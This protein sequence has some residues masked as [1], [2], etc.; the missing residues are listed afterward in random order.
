MTKLDF[1]KEDYK[2]TLVEFAPGS[3]VCGEVHAPGGNKSLLANNRTFV[4]KL[5]L[6][7]DLGGV[8]KGKE[9]LF[10]YGLGS[11][12][13]IESVKK[14]EERTGLKAVALLCNGSGH[15][16]FIRKW[17]NSFPEPFEVWA[18][19][20]KTPQTENGIALMKDFPN[21]WQLADNS[22]T[23]HHVNQLYKFFGSGGDLQVDCVLF[24]QLFTYTD[25]ISKKVGSWT[26]PDDQPETKPTKFIFG[27]MMKQ[28]GGE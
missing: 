22:T 23:P 28:F 21:R 10:V 15:H 13:A 20:T 19:P 27:G 9:C 24:N 18:C 3:W 6:R 11:D 7:E 8:S 12:G 4:L 16:I 26:M 1:S 17:Y 2:S 5:K 14:L 25:A